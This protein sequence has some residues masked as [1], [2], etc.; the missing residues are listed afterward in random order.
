MMRKLLSLVLVTVAIFSVVGCCPV[1]TKGGIEKY[2]KEQILEDYGADIDSGLFLFPDDTATIEQAS[3][4]SSFRTG[5]F[6][7]DGYII[8]HAKYGE[9]NY[10]KEVDRL[11]NVKCVVGN[12]EARVLFDTESY[13]L[14]A[15][16]ASDGFDY[17]YEYA[18]VDDENFE[19][20]YMFL[21][22]P[23]F[24]KPKGFE[25]YMKLDSSEYDID[26]ALDRFSI[27]TREQEDGSYLEYYDEVH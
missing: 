6:D 13:I 17:V 12:T 20:T 3:F 18:L 21:S 1:E 9:E 8:L 14:P 2:N 24:L 27:Y 23:K 11:A 19:I 26:D 10:K 5:L 16:V 7:T 22:Y 25:K 15:Y 4:V